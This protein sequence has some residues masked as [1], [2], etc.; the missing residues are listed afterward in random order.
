MLIL[1]IDTL[2][3]ILFPYDKVVSG[4][5]DGCSLNHVESQY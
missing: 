2:K 5:S 4:I 3:N 1:V